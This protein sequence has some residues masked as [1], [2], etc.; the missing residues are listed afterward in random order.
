[1][2][3]RL[4]LIVVVLLL[5]AA[6]LQKRGESPD[7]ATPLV[8]MRVLIVEETGAK[9]SPGVTTTLNSARSGDIDA[10]LDEHCAKE[11]TGATANH[12]WDKDLDVSQQS[13]F[14]QNAMARKRDSL[15]W[16]II[17]NGRRGFEGPLPESPEALLELLKK[18]E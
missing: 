2:R 14:W 9:Y 5:V 12:V 1:M 8:G 13:R 11:K 15:P 17:S 16:I 6:A 18:Y 10:W 4:A 7:P 3:I